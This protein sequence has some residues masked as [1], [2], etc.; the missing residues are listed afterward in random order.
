MTLSSAHLEAFQVLAQ[1]LNFTK[2]AEKLHVTQSALSQR[3]KNLEEELNTTLF[4]RDRAG[5]KLTAT[6]EDLVR[7][8]RC[9]NS[10]EEEFLS[11]L[12]SQDLTGSI[13]I[14]GF[15]TVM[16]SVIVPRLAPL[17]QKHNGLQFQNI[18]DEIETL[19][20][21]LQRGEID[22]MI[23][24]RKEARDELEAVLL[25]HEQNVLIQQ[26]KYK[27]VD[28]YL[29]H[30]PDDETTF[31]YLKSAGKKSKNI[32][33]RYLADIYGIIE[34]VRHGLGRAVVP[35]HLIDEKEFEII[36][37]KTILEVPVYLHF[38]SQPYY[39]KLHQEI[40]KTLTHT[41]KI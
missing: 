39:S 4:I 23:L 40:L 7:Y 41:L 34:G 18:V 17:L 1:T 8:C 26:K 10:L 6:A 30:T 29:D 5:L 12:K 11:S 37:P 27:G 2:A 35:K 21:K 25:G 28:I 16:S 32:E 14:G 36:E 38:Y 24:D 13:R 31:R 3:I 20:A 19:P 9:K 22:Y 33:R 15:S